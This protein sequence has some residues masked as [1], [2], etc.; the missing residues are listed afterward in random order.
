MHLLMYLSKLS[1][2]DRPEFL[3]I[4]WIS[5]S[6][7]YNLYRYCGARSIYMYNTYI[8]MVSRT[9]KVELT[10]SFNNSYD[11]PQVRT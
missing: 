9:T 11:F 10:I 1:N 7:A 8:S 2:A 4:H 5:K 6:T 3:P